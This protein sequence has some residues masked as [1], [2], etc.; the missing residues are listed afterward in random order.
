M[1]FLQPWIVTLFRLGREKKEKLKLTEEILLES[2]TYNYI[3]VNKFYSCARIDSLMI[4]FFFIA[5][6]QAEIRLD[7]TS[8]ERKKG[9]K[10]GSITWLVLG[11]SL[12]D[13]Q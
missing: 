11:I 13:E 3:K 6:S 7:L 4:F 9:L 8:D 10:S 1:N 2:M 5:P 12:E